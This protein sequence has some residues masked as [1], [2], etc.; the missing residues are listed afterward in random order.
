MV[1]A[2]QLSMNRV[3]GTFPLY[4]GD[5]GLSLPDHCSFQPS[6]LV[7]ST[8]RPS[9]PNNCNLSPVKQD[10]PHFVHIVISQTLRVQ[11]VWPFKHIHLS[12][13]FTLTNS[14]CVLS[15]ALSRHV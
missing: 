7:S 15:H 5:A 11:A 2:A 8:F 13:V 6:L 1:R 14:Y 3:T 10:A 12:L 9:I 4:R